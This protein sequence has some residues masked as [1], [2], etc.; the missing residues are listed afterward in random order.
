MKNKYVFFAVLLLFISITA[1]Q[2]DST[3]NQ[4]PVA[5]ATSVSPITLPIDTIVLKGK[6][7]AFNGKI[8]AYLW[9]QVSGPTATTIVNPGSDST[10]VRGF[11]E[12]KYIFQFMVTDNLGATGVDTVL[13]TVNPNP[14]KTIIF[15]P[16]RNPNEKIL[17]KLGSQDH[18]TVGILNELLM[19]A[20]TVGSD[21]H[22][23]R[24]LLKFDLSSI[25]ASATIQ[26]AHLFIY[27]NTPPDNGNK[28][29]ANYGSDNSFL[30]QQISADWTPATTNWSSQ[31][32]VS[33]TNQIT[34]P[35]T[36]QSVLD[37]DIDVTVMVGN[38]INTNKNYGFMLRLKNETAYTSRI[39]VGSYNATKMDK[40]PKLVI[41]Y[42]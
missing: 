1:C 41:T 2:K 7:T 3:S 26:S 16:S 32:A 30:L 35:S 37:L 24:S 17:V 11:K 42:K 31:P 25:P 14:I 27:S 40:Y 18:S 10:V 12:G 22:F 29:D 33:A 36:S 23:A 19:D 21:A 8:V 4:V 6:G 9:S 13:I 39:F 15:Q 38:M 28:V 34:I 5:N 20:W